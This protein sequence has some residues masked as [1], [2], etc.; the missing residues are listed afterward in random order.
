[1]NDRAHDHG[2]VR[3]HD[4]G[5]GEYVRDRDYAHVRDY[6]RARGH[7]GNV[8]GERDHPLLACRID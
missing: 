8:H 4:Y 1:M 3:D 6:V 7:H 2:S 5:H